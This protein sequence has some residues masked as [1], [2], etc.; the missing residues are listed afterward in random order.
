MN[1]LPEIDFLTEEEIE[2]IEDERYYELLA[3]IEAWK[4]ER[5]SECMSVGS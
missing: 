4:E 2:E 5:A 1:A 3:S